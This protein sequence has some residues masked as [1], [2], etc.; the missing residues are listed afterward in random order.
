MNRNTSLVI[1]T[2]VIALAIL[3]LTVP[4]AIKGQQPKKLD[5]KSKTSEAK[6][7]PEQQQALELV[8]QLADDLKRESDKPEAAL[9]QSQIADVLWDFDGPGA[10]AIFK[11]AFET[12]RQP[13]GDGLS[14][15]DK[16]DYLRRQTS[17]L[18]EIMRHAGYHDK[19]IMDDWAKQLEE[20][21]ANKSSTDQT[22]SVERTELLA[23]IALEVS[24]K[25]PERGLQLGL[26]SLSG[27]KVPEA[28]GRLLFALSDRDRVLSDTLFAAA[29]LNIQRNGYDYTPALISLTN[30][31]FDGRGRPYSTA[32]KTVP[33]LIELFT[34]AAETHAGR[35]LAL[36][37]SGDQNIP[38]SSA[39]IF[40]FLASRALP[41][42]ELNAAE[43]LSFMRM[44]LDMILAGMS[45]Q[46]RQQTDTLLSQ[47]LSETTSGKSDLRVETKIERAEKEKNPEVRDQLL[48]RIALDLVY[49]ENTED[50]ALTV[51]G[52]IQDMDLRNR[53][54]DDINI[55]L[56]SR[57]FGAGNYDAA[58]RITLRLNDRGLRSKMLAEQAKVFLNGSKKNG[59]A[60]ELLSEAYFTA[61]KGENTPDKLV[62]LL[63]VAEEMAK[64]DSARA[65]NILFEVV[66]TS[67]SLKADSAPVKDVV[68]AFPFKSVNYIVVNG[69][70]VNAEERATAKSITF[71][72]I[73][74]LSRIDFLQTRSIGEG[75]ENKILRAKFLLA[76]AKGVLVKT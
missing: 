60:L 74:T 72:Q 37:S 71:D 76:V 15:T 28:F 4:I 64:I 55:V 73:S 52:K 24:S 31:T 21:R 50:L 16:Q 65:F 25:N 2:L 23:Q 8:T 18:Q 40:R 67:N 75:I 57:R 10:R 63:D 59:R 58:Y 46:Q 5:K 22:P 69:K 1:K 70:E 66:K 6:L 26:L 43:R 44:K 45:Q 17:A 9:I 54:E 62:A 7:L 27:S 32:I 34:N 48:R 35:W 39:A 47:Q 30:Y 42:I 56:F 61:M 33:A 13:P 36:R 49:S 29:I 68:G 51:I 12:V 41:I 3:F 53:T 11:L 19:Q 14:Q 20:E 38:E